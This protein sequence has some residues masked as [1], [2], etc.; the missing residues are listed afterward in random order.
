MRRGLLVVASLAAAIAGA[1]AA[2]L[3]GIIK[4]ID[5][6]KDAITLANGMTFVLPKSLKPADLTVGERVKVT[7]EPVGKANVASRVVDAR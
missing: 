4:S 5:F 1:N 2:E 7:Y 6:A 3:S